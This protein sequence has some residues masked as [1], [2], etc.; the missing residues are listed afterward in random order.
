MTATG[1]V[2]GSVP[3]TLALTLGAPAS[4]GPFTPGIDHDYTASTTANV[5]STAGDAALSVS[6]P[7]HLTNGSFALSEPLRVEA[8]Q[9]RL[10][11][12][13]V[14]RP[15]DG[16]VPPAHRRDAAAAHRHLREDADLH[17]VDHDAVTQRPGAAARAAAPDALDGSGD[18]NV[19]ATDPRAGERPV[20]SGNPLWARGTHP[21]EHQGVPAWEAGGS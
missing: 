19:P 11:R 8:L 6:D 1:G 16:H 9:E 7:G 21:G 3:A 18:G 2:G 10:E 20:G 4:F 15:G 5:V 13:G 17:A 12:A 14:Q